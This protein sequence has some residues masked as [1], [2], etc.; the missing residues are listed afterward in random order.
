MS[1]LAERR[2]KAL[3]GDATALSVLTK[4]HGAQKRIMMVNDG[5]FQRRYQLGE[6]VMDSTHQHM[7]IR[8]ATRVEDNKEMVVK[9]RFKPKCFKCREDEMDWR[10]GTEYMMNLP[11]T[12]GVAE[13]YEVME[14]TKAFYIVQEKAEGMDL[15]ELLAHKKSF[16]IQECKDILR[17]LLEAMAHLHENSAVHKDIKLENVMVCPQSGRQPSGGPSP[18]SVKIIDFD[19]VEEWDPTSPNAKD[20][21][22]TDQYI[23]Q[24]AYAGKYTPSSDVFAAGVIAYRLVGGKFPFDDKI[25]D[26]EAGENWVGSPKMKQIR[27]RLKQ[28]KVDW[29]VGDFK[30]HAGAVDLVQK[31]LAYDEAS[32]P[33]ARECANHPWIQKG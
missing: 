10:R 6:I 32:R 26:D 15:F 14:D 8:F 18:A 33:S 27:S 9:L 23:A 17:Q 28:S 3:G 2:N 19:T 24:E 5:E 11:T 31:M 12:Q 30:D 4:P 22:G 20:V 1:S 16:P 13:L 7:E 25:F 21:L 29:N